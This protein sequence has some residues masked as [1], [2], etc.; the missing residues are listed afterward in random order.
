MLPH[1]RRRQR[2]DGEQRGG[3]GQAH[4]GGGGHQSG[5]VPVSSASRTAAQR[6]GNDGANSGA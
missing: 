6:S 5:G 3:R 4:V 2:V 1:Q